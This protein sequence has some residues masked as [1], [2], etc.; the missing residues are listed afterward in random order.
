MEE[1]TTEEK[2]TIA[3][4]FTEFQ[5][6]GLRSYGNYLNTQ[7]EQSEGKSNREAYTRYIKNEIERNSKKIQTLEA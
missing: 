4:K 1:I 5:L 7:L 6:S 2:S 3:K